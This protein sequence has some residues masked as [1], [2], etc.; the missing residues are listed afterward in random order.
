M[1]YGRGQGDLRRGHRDGITGHALE[2]AS[3]L[4]MVSEVTLGGDQTRWLKGRRVKGA[5]ASYIGEHPIQN[6]K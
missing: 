4:V 1:E 2:R 5:Y 6:Q 3:V